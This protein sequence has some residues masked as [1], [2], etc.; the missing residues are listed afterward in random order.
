M[1]ISLIIAGLI[2]GIYSSDSV[3]SFNLGTI[4]WVLSL[5]LGINFMFRKKISNSKPWIYYHRILAVIFLI[6]MILHIQDVK[7]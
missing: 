3:L 5:L 4:A 1:G 6:I 2:H 7:I